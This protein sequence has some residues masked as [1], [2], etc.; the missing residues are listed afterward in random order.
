MIRIKAFK[1][2][3]RIFFSFTKLLNKKTV[4]GIRKYAN[5]SVRSNDTLKDIDLA[6]LVLLTV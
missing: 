1:P 6:E 4:F 5:A 3:D 2:F